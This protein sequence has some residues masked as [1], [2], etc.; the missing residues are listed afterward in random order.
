MVPE[1]GMRTGV[2]QD[3]TRTG[4]VADTIVV[5]ARDTVRKDTAVRKAEGGTLSIDNI[6]KLFQQTERR[7]RK[8]SIAATRKKKVVVKKK[9]AKQVR[10]EPSDSVS[11]R[12]VTAVPAGNTPELLLFRASSCEHFLAADSLRDYKPLP[13]KKKAASLPEVTAVTETP[14]A[15]A[16]KR[17]PAFLR[18]N[19]ILGVLIL[20]FLLITWT[21]IRF[22]KLLNQTLSALWN[23]KN[24]N[25]LFRNKSSL[26]QWTSFFLA[27]NYLLTATLFFY[28]FL[29]AFDPSL[30]QGTM[31]H[32]RIYLNILVLVAAVYF[33]FLIV[34][35]IVDLITLAGEPLKEFGHF[36][37]LFFHN[38]GLYLF[39]LT[40]IIPYVYESVARQLLWV[41]LGLFLILYIFR[42]VKLITIFIRER[43]SIFLMILYLCTLEILPVAILLKYLS[44]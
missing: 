32:L 33:Y 29:K 28:F 5:K 13:S 25:T 15:V 12:Q 6:E 37:K 2:Q 22:G 44:R 21:K 17:E 39:P 23:Y 36:T 43:F 42:V 40:A 19:W 4:S 9:A 18:E 14:A 26:Y 31:T 1:Q 38:A 24:A 34:I 3:T 27:F 41:G 11:L 30:F 8:D 20:A 10:T 7:L 16:V 35:R